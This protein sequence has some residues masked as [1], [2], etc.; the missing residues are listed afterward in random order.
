MDTLK[1]QAFVTAARLGSLTQAAQVL[2]YTQ[3]GITRMIH[4]L[5]EEFGFPLFIRSKKGVAL[6]ENGR[7]MV[8]PLEEIVSAWS[9]ASQLASDIRGS[10]RGSLTVGSYF[11]ISAMIMPAIIAEFETLY[12]GIKIRIREGGNTEM[13]R[14]LADNAVDCCFCARPASLEGLDWLPL[15]Q[16]EMVAWLPLDHPWAQAP[17]FPVREFQNWPF[18]HTSPNKDTD[19]D[20][21]I[22]KYRLQLEDAY[23]T[24]DGFSTYNM[25]A[26][27]IGVS[28]NQRLISRDWKKKIA[29]VP[30]EPREFIWLG[31]ALPSLK[32]ASPATRKFIDCARKIT[33]AQKDLEPA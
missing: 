30:L 20:R 13:S 22:A 31:I 15:F 2:G 1:C 14:W 29:Q 6:S 11:S 10:I 19:Q 4:S 3:S 8:E 23:T 24:L 33:G 5:E 26:Q 27:G 32:T 21:L 28:C 7:L 9:N 25:V 18:I 16:D 12:P 17:A